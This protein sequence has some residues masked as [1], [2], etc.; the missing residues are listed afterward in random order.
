M[1]DG[2]HQ[3]GELLVECPACQGAGEHPI[4]ARDP[5]SG[6]YDTEHC[7]LCEGEGEVEANVARE[8]AQ[9]NDVC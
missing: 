5:L 9:A 4:G 2:D 8:Y 3:W 7:R 6:Y 1:T